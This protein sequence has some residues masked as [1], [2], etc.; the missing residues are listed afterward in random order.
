MATTRN[1]QEIVMSTHHRSDSFRTR[2]E[3]TLAGVIFGGATAL[4]CSGTL[5]VF[6]QGASLTV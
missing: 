5:A 4:I 3:R 6:F 2:F 1:T